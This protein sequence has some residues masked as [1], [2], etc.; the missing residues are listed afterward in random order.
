MF[1]RI[2]YPTDFSDIS[3]KALDY[4]IK[5]KEAGTREVVLV[6]IIELTDTVR[7]PMEMSWSKKPASEEQT[8]LDAQLDKAVKNELSKIEAELRATGLDVKTVVGKGTPLKEILRLEKDEGVSA[9]VIGSHGKSNLKEVLLGSVSEN[10]V[11]HS[12][13]PV[14]VI[15]R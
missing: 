9:I 10:V 4:V 3:K 13:A 2:L 7:I 6:H 14:L 5:L 12:T 1:S 15:K 11:R 8:E